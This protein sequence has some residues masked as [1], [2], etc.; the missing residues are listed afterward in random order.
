MKIINA[1]NVLLIV[2]NVQIHK[3]INVHHVYHHS[4]Y[5]KIN[6]CNLVQ[7]VNTK[8]MILNVQTVMLFVVNVLQA[9]Y[10]LV[11][12]LVEYFKEN[13]ARMFV[14]ITIMLILKVTLV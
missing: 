4:Y 6:V 13:N 3:Q 8:L 1:L 12:L 11:V 14:I 7:M 10:V 9:V 5:L 2:H